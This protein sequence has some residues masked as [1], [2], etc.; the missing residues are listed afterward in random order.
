[1]DMGRRRISPA[2]RSAIHLASVNSYVR[3]TTLEAVRG[4]SSMACPYGSLLST[5]APWSVFTSNL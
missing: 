2:V 4:R 5:S 1:M 3:V